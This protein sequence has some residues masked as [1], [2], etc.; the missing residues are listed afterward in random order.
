MTYDSRERSAQDGQP[1]ELYTFA[2]DTL[3][4][5]YT[6][7]DRQV[8]AASAT[9]APSPI[10]RSRIESS[11]QLS[12]ATITITA[13]REIEIAEMHRVVAPSTPITVLVQQIH[14]GDSEVA[15]IWSG[16]VVAVDFAGPE[17]RITCEP[18]FTS[19][20]RLGLRRVYQRSCPHVLYGSACGVSRTAYQAAG[21]V[22]SVSGLQVNV[23]AAAAQPDG[24]FA[25][26]YLQFELAPSIFERR[27]ISGHVGDALT[28]AALPQGLAAGTPVTLFPGCDH[29][30]ATCSGK[31]SN[32]ANYG[33]FPFMPTK[34]PFGGDPIY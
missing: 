20:K 5:R 2:R 15:T 34:N 26:G 12:R 19:I 22:A 17:A 27:F 4:W 9:F 14:A 29:T 31:F 1:I 30:L 23:A 32:T 13:P 8:T 24:Y 3:R 10:A 28:V 7:A 6:S 33:G 21:T 11:Q 18:I 25:G 16:R